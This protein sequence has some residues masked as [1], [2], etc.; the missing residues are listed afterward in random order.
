MATI[1]AAITEYNKIITVTVEIEGQGD[2]DSPPWQIAAASRIG[3]MFDTFTQSFRE[4]PIPAEIERDEEL[5]GIY[6]DALDQQ[7]QRF[8]NEAIDKYRFCLTTATNVR[9]FNEWSRRCEE[10]LHRLNPREYP[11]SSELRGPPNYVVRPPSAPGAEELG[12]GDDET[13]AEAPGDQS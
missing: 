6:V 2:I 3:E 5:Y 1:G 8:L 12:S 11:V 4:A 7:S 10:N 13:T 9:W